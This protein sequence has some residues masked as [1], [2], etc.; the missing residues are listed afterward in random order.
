MP[1]A[2]LDLLACA[3]RLL[4]AEGEPEHRAAASRAYYAAYHS[5]TPELDTLDVVPD[6]T[7]GV[8][9]RLAESF[10]QNAN[11]SIKSIGYLLRQAHG[12]RVRA[13]Y[14]LS[15][16]FSRDEAESVIST[17]EKILD[18]LDEIQGR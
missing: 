12:E 5:A 10:I 13:D 15:N 3:R 2:P 18:K 6:A 14:A 9:N 17:V 16:D 8:H 7:G 1:I 4:D 11:F